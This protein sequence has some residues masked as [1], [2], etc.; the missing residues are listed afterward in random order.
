ML[1]RVSYKEFNSSQ[2]VICNSYSIVV[3]CPT[4]CCL[5][6]EESQ[7]TGRSYYH[8]SSRETAPQCRRVGDRWPT[9]SNHSPF[10]LAQRQSIRTLTR[11]SRPTKWMMGYL[12]VITDRGE[13]IRSIIEELFFV[14]GFRFSVSSSRFQCSV[15]SVQFSQICT[16]FITGR[17]L[18]L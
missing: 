1:Q 16:L 9:I 7:G 12:Y 11:S 18:L 4:A 3:K 17:H 6:M 14:F 10:R 8:S 15:F 5:C 2:T 13:R